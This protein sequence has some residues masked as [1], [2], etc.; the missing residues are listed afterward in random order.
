MANA[1]MSK[2][3]PTTPST[4]DT[5]LAELKQLEQQEATTTITKDAQL[6]HRM[7]HVLTDISDYYITKSDTKIAYD[8]AKRAF[9]K[10]PLHAK[11][12]AALGVALTKREKFEQAVPYLLFP[13]EQQK[14]KEVDLPHVCSCLAHCY[15]NMQHFDNA[16]VFAEFY[17]QMAK[18]PH[19]A[20]ARLQLAQCYEGLDK[21]ADA[22]KAI[23]AIAQYPNDRLHSLCLNTKGG[24]YFRLKKMN[25]A[26]QAYEEAIKY[27]HTLSVSERVGAM[28]SR[29]HV[30][31][32][33]GKM[34]MVVQIAN[35]AIEMAPLMAM[36]Y[37]LRCKANYALKNYDQ[38][39]Q[40]CK[41]MLQMNPQD[42]NARIKLG[43]SL[44]GVGKIDEGIEH[45][46]MIPNDPDA[47]IMIQE[48]T[49][50]KKTGKDKY[51]WVYDTIEY[52]DSETLKDRC[53]Y[54]GLV[55]EK[56][57]KCTA[58][59]QIGYCD[60]ECQKKHWPQHK[61]QCKKKK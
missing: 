28:I 12:N 2:A 49:Y 18:G 34:A 29:G 50:A 16:L 36:S 35:K 32:H 15:L 43:A 59:R 42:E 47:K 23:D 6:E 40:D 61:K 25:E 48:V 7:I 9:A 33:M 37:E 4:I 38:V 14:G 51:E 17:L 21:Y 22:V 13:F 58:C 30:L 8:Y 44:C 41:Q 31:V 46:K 54:C 55:N 11:A 20:Y 39:I 56:L 1:K 52:S 5:L 27:E 60:A 45:F 10:N 19:V 24:A 3:K 57:K 53:G 26:L